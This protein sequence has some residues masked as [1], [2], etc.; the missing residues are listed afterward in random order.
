MGFK[1]GQAVRVKKSSPESL[2]FWKSM[3][4]RFPYLICPCS[5]NPATVMIIAELLGKTAC[6]VQMRDAPTKLSVFKLADLKEASE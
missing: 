1:V 5:V 3:S 2:I 6:L 4:A